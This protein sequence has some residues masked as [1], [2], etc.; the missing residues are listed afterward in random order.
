MIEKYIS[1]GVFDKLFHECAKFYNIHEYKLDHLMFRQWFVLH[2]LKIEV[3]WQ[4]TN[5]LFEEETLSPFHYLLAEN[6][7]Y[8]TAFFLRYL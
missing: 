7:E 8:L 1:H 6:E 3:R 5:S 2:N 4:P